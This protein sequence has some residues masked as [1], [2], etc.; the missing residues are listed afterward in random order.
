MQNCYSKEIYFV[1]KLLIYKC[2]FII[3]FK[4][5][6]TAVFEALLEAFT[7]PNTVINTDSFL[8]SL[9]EQ[10]NRQ[11]PQ[12]QSHL[13]IEFQVSFIIRPYYSYQL[14]FR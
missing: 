2:T 12:N 9:E 5:Q 10:Q 11:V 4:E 1:Y 6:Y 7:I 3:Y 13:K 8:T 14:C